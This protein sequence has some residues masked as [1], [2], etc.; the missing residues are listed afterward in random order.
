MREIKF[1]NFCQICNKFVDCTTDEV[2]WGR[3]GMEFFCPHHTVA[4]W[5]Q[6]MQYTGL[7]D[8]NK[9][10]IYEG[11]ILDP[12]KREVL[13]CTNAKCGSVYNAAGWY[14]QSHECD[15][16]PETLGLF[17]LGRSQIDES[18]II[19]NIHENADLLKEERK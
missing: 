17:N 19:G 8:K 16:R 12:G 5:T 1:R 10:E 4:T 18:E 13:W 9:V 7:Y 15:G 6:V 11:D 14:S 3:D 2:H